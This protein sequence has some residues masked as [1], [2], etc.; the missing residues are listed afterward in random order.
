MYTWKPSAGTWSLCQRMAASLCGVSKTQSQLDAIEKELDNHFREKVERIWSGNH[1]LHSYEPDAFY[2]EWLKKE[3][4]MDEP[5]NFQIQYVKLKIR[6]KEK[7]DYVNH[8]G[9]SGDSPFLKL[10]SDLLPPLLNELAIV[11]TLYTVVSSFF[12]L[13][14]KFWGSLEKYHDKVQYPI[15]PSPHEMVLEV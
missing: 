10:C 15:P 3:L 8:L 13:L 6:M 12:D 2:S 11:G 7:M 1:D 4:D 14:N 9:L 5:S